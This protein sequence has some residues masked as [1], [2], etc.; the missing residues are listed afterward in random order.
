M[1]GQL[2]GPNGRPIS[3]AI[4]N[5]KAEPPKLGTQFG[6]W[7]GR[8]LHYMTLPGGGIVQFD[9]SKLTLQDYRAMRDHYQVNVSLAVL[10]FMQHQ[11]EFKIMCTDKKIA[12]FCDEQLHN[13]WTMLNRS[14][15]TAN[16]AGYSP[17]ALEWDN[18][19]NGR[20]VILKKVKD[21]VPEECAVNWAKEDLW[22]PPGHI[23]P[24]TRK[25]DGIKQW[26]Y[27]WPI[28][29]DNSFWYPILMEH[30]NYYGRK[31]LR[32]AFQSWFFSILV[33][34]FA[35][36]Y[37]ERFGEPTPVGR[38]PYD[39]PI[40][41]APGKMMQGNEYMLHILQNL[42]SRG[43]VVLPNS[44]TQD[45]NGKESFDYDIQYLESQMRGADFER[46]MTRLDEEISLALFTPILLLRTADVGS[47]N[48]GQGHMQVYQY[49][50]NALNDDR[51]MYLDN[52][53]LSP[54]VNY[55]FS[56]SAPRAKVKFQKL[57]TAGSDMMK[58]MIVELIKSG[59][60][61]PNLEE[62]GTMAGLTINEIKQTVAPPPV[63]NQPPPDPNAPP[64]DPNAPPAPGN[65]VAQ[66]QATAKE[67]VDRV[68]GQIEAAWRD[69]TFGPDLQVN[70][71]YKRKFERAAIADGIPDGH[72]AVRKTYNLMDAWI[73][74]T[75]SL[76]RE[77]FSS[78]ES[79]V[80][81][82]EQVLTNVVGDLTHAA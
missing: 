40:E 77:E 72:E 30:G 76:G 55:N 22:A 75:L 74:D 68:R 12:D 61:I 14:M 70:M 73:E 44:R 58:A 34:L 38:A 69:G 45:V 51:G 49:M 28:P 27:H 59:H 10:S 25:F 80:G 78:P 24:K 11:S 19:Y 17:N 2:L 56:I 47:Y 31:L 7:A 39:E 50:L 15:S 13:N 41:Y 3:S 32:P 65:R 20:S 43:A 79:F 33:H 26:G 63:P 1:P 9:L 66:S 16:W 36:R 82:F 42:R 8:D 6:D 64:P 67:I 29:V 52:Y 23:A 81:M 21:L 53:I 62:L 54:M 71:G 4:Y 46:Y 48:L 37:Y 18:D 57:G 60:G 35:N 5:K